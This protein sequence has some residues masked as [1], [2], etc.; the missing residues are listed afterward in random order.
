LAQAAEEGRES[1]LVLVRHGRVPGGNAEVELVA[2]VAVPIRKCE[3]YGELSDRDRHHGT[4]GDRWPRRAQRHARTAST[5]RPRSASS[6][7]GPTE[8]RIS[9][10]SSHSYTG[11]STRCS[12]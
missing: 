11:T 4:P 6:L 7:Y 8:T 9:V 1:A 3:Q 12:S 10:V 2:V 5:S